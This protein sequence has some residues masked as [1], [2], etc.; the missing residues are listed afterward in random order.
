S[1]KLKS[2][3]LRGSF[4]KSFDCLLPFWL[5][6][7]VSIARI[8]PRSGWHE[9][10]SS[11]IS[12]IPVPFSSRLH[13]DRHADPGQLREIFLVPVRQP[14]T[15]MRLRATDLFGTRR[16]VDPITRLVQPE[17]NRA[18]RIVR[19]GRQAQPP[20]QFPPFRRIEKAL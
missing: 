12:I 14:K 2:R 16:S 19:S 3:V 5:P 4:Q 1:P 10:A 17:P 13:I 15:A 7:P 9:L 8:Y 18:H 20:D 11:S 6:T